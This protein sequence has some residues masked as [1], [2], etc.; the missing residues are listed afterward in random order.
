MIAN[1][2]SWLVGLMVLCCLACAEKEEGCLDIY[3]TNFDFDADL[4]CID[5]CTYPIFELKV[6]HYWD[7]LSPF[8]YGD[9]IFEQIDSLDTIRINQL[10]FFI[11]DI[12]LHSDTDSLTVASVFE[13]ENLNDNVFEVSAALQWIDQK[14]TQAAGLGPFP[15]SGNIITG[16]SFFIGFDPAYGSIDPL[17]LAE[18]HPA[19]ISS[20]SLNWSSTFGF[21]DARFNFSRQGMFAA[22]SIDV[23]LQFEAYVYEAFSEVQELEVG[24]D[25]R[26]DLRLYYKDLIESCDL[27]NASIEQIRDCLINNFAGAIQFDS[28]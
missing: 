18:G 20:D 19:G 25:V 27:T 2:F 9:P 23:P 21:L 7:S 8:E 12:Y 15:H 4:A 16:V 5:C 14:S 26:L 22:D 24:N 3:A 17:G 28:F 13:L 1:K 10:G 6:S 11:T